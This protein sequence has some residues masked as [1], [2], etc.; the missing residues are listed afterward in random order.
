MILDYKNYDKIVKKRKKADILSL[1]SLLLL[2]LL[3][4]IGILYLISWKNNRNLQSLLFDIQINKIDEYINTHYFFFHPHKAKEAIALSSLVNNDYL[5]AEKFFKEEIP[6]DLPY[7]WGKYAKLLLD[8]GYYWGANLYL[9][10]LLKGYKNEDLDN[11]YCIV[12]T[13]L[14][15]FMFSNQC[16]D[17]VL[18]NKELANYALRIKHIKKMGRFNWIIDRNGTSLI[19]RKLGSKEI[20]YDDESMEWFKTEMLKLKGDDF[21]NTIILTIDGRIQRIAY[22]SLGKYDGTLLLMSKD[23]QLL[24]ATSKS[25]DK[26]SP[27]F[28]RMLKPGSIVKI[29][30]LSAAMRNN[31]DLKSIFPFECKGFIVPYDKI[32]FYDWIEHKTVLDVTDALATSCNISF[33]IIGN[34][35]GSKK[36][37]KELEEF[38]IGKEITLEEMKFK[39]GEIIDK[40]SDPIYEYS[41][42]IGDNYVMIS[43]ILAVM[44]VSSLINDGIA[45]HPYFMKSKETL[46]GNN[47]FNKNSEIYG[48]FTNSEYAEVIKDGMIKAVG[49]D[50]GTGKRAKLTNYHIALK[51]GTAG[52]KEPAYD[53]IIIGYAPNEDPQVAFALFALHSGKA[54]LEGANIIKNFLE[55]SLPYYINKK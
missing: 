30:T 2:I 45:P 52:S 14:N 51:T 27:L 35:L 25:A 44:W 55:Q 19:Y 13:I 22:K 20:Y 1:I 29:V 47:F 37:K 54:S 43:P 48:K 8:K 4:I 6:T 53:S 34:K 24:A 38:G 50:F 5:N 39:A 26:E 49:L 16:I 42:A 33:G 21:Y 18:K 41:L 40:V 9:N 36:L 32:V 23:G 15:D 10:Y 28:I 12:S 46:T 17:L 31:L 3:I 11:F 7:Y